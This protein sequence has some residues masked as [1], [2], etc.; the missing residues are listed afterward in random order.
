[1]SS[2]PWPPPSS[3]GGIRRSDRAFQSRNSYALGRLPFWVSATLSL[4][5]AQNPENVHRMV[6]QL[7]AL[8][9]ERYSRPKPPWG[10][11]SFEAHEHDQHGESH[12]TID[13]R[14]VS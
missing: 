6:D 4:A 10:A 2:H 7:V 9:C 14:W 5:A 13:V 11:V 3:P 8:T 12:W 1:M